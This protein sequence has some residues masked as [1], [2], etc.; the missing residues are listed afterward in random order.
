[1]ND[2]ASYDRGSNYVWSH[3]PPW[4]RDCWAIDPGK[5][6]SSHASRLQVTCTPMHQHITL[7]YGLALQEGGHRKKKKHCWWERKELAEEEA[8]GMM[9]RRGEKQGEVNMGESQ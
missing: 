2:V 1:M 9:K 8:S 7:L 6:P 5:K 4:G 3:H